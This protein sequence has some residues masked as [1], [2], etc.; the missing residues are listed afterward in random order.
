MK[1]PVIE[2]LMAT[3]LLITPL[4]SGVAYADEDLGD[5]MERME[6]HWQMMV[7]E[8][9][10]MKRQ[11]MMGEH[12]KMMEQSQGMMMH[13]GKSMHGD[14]HSAPERI[15]LQNMLDLQRNMMDMMR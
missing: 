8:P 12:E 14:M 4:L 11:A 9:D 1:R 15:D 10:A 3:L 6:K 2:K 5:A 13:D 7:S